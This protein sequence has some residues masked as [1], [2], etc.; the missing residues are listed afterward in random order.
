MSWRSRTTCP[1][2]LAVSW[3]RSTRLATKRVSRSMSSS[4]DRD[5]GRPAISTTL[6]ASATFARQSVLSFCGSPCMYT[7]SWRASASCAGGRLLARVMTMMEGCCERVGARSSCITAMNC[8]HSVS[9]CRMRTMWSPTRQISSRTSTLLQFTPST[10]FIIGSDDFRRLDREDACPTCPTLS[11]CLI[12]FS[13]SE[14][15]FAGSPRPGG[16]GA[17]GILSVLVFIIGGP[18]TLRGFPG[19]G[20]GE[21]VF[22]AAGTGGRFSSLP[23]VIESRF[24]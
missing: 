15:M 17:Q 8:C 21:G 24:A 3:I 7:T 13:E 4:S 6:L 9:S 14:L 12:I 23:R 2:E 20:D 11:N 10:T 16:P 19:A 1:G 18:P 22:A 5:D